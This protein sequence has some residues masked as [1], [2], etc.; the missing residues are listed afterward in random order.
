MVPQEGSSSDGPLVSHL[1]QAQVREAAAARARENG[2]SVD[3]SMPWVLSLSTAQRPYVWTAMLQ[4]P[5]QP[6]PGFWLLIDDATGRTDFVM[7]MVAKAPGPPA[8]SDWLAKVKNGIQQVKYPIRL[9]D[10][11]GVVQATGPRADS[12]GSTPDGRDFLEFT[13]RRERDGPARFELRCYIVT[14]EGWTG[15]KI[16]TAA[17][18]AYIDEAINRYVLGD[19]TD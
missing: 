1:T 10:F 4:E 12:G 15:P 14:P 11:L 19:G 9:E 8:G 16:V 7:P 17:E 13:L 5:G 18:L 6:P 2:F 3:A